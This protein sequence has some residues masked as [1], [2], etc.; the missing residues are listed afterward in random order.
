MVSRLLGWAHRCSSAAGLERAGRW[1]T[2]IGWCLDSKSLAVLLLMEL[3]VVV[4]MLVNPVEAPFL[5]KS[6]HALVERAGMDF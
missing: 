6:G 2:M 4:G 3:R 5:Q 1:T